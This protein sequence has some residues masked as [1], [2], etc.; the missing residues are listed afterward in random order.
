MSFLSKIFGRGDV[1]GESPEFKSLLDTSIAELRAKNTGHQEGWGLGKAARWDLD[2][3][4][5][6]LIFTFNDGVIATCPAQI[7]G[8]FNKNAGSW[9]WSWANPSIVDVLKRDALKV[10]DY[11][12]RHQITRLTSDKWTGAEEDAWAMAALACKLCDAQGS[13]RG[14]AGASYVF[15]TFGKVELSKKS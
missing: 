6:D 12:Q 10:K 3:S 5:G 8:S 9:L 2:Q 7:I 4:R 14:P 15:M 11:G 1:H 13:Y